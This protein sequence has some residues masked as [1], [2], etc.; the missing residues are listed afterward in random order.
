MANSKQ[1]LTLTIQGIGLLLMVLFTAFQPWLLVPFN[2]RNRYSTPLHKLELWFIESN[3]GKLKRI[4]KSTLEFKS[5]ET[6]Y[7]IIKGF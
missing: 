5:L 6:V 3:Q 4:I 2:L 1:T 7:T